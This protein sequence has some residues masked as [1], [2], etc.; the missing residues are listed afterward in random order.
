MFSHPQEISEIKKV[1]IANCCLWR[2]TNQQVGGDDNAEIPSLNCMKLMT[3]KFIQII[4][5]FTLVFFTWGY[6]GRLS[7][8]KGIPKFVGGMGNMIL[9]TTQGVMV[10]WEAQEKKIWGEILCHVIRCN[11]NISVCVWLSV[12]GRRGELG[13]RMYSVH[14]VIPQCFRCNR[15]CDSFSQHLKELWPIEKHEKR[16]SGESF[17]VILYLPLLLS[18]DICMCTTLLRY[19]IQSN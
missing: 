9:W 16:K 7:K 15:I 10:D 8:H 13:S 1:G 19:E 12:G 5:H 17:Y 6:H 2:S 14:N 11:F 18:F 3:Y 4:S